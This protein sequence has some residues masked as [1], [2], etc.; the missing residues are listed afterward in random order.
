[1]N[2]GNTA[3]NITSWHIVF[4][5]YCNLKC[6]YCST[7]YGQF[8]NE[9]PSYMKKVTSLK[10]AEWIFRAPQKNKS[11]SLCFEGGETLLKFKEFIEYVQYLNSLAKTHN[12]TLSIDVG[13]NGVLLDKDIMET[14]AANNI[15]LSFSIDGSEETHDLCRKDHQ[16]DKT[17]QK[18]L[19]NWKL[20]KEISRNSPNPVIC[21]IQSVYSGHSDL[22]EVL[23]FWHTQGERIVNV[24]IQHPSRFV[25]GQNLEDLEKR[26]QRYLESFKKIAYQKAALL[27]IPTFLTDF[28]GPN[29]L[30]KIWKDIF[31]GTSV[32]PCGAAVNTLGVT[33]EGDL[34]PCETFI[35]SPTDQGRGSFWKMGDV[36]NGLD[37]EKIKT[38]LNARN[39]VLTE[40]D[41]CDTGH[42][43]RGGCFAAGEKDDE[44]SLNRVGGCG[45]M[46][47][48][49]HIARESY[50]GMK[51]QF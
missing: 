17:Q 48:I 5:Q 2:I 33:A 38:F 49:I 12:V 32:T 51:E 39:R 28:K 27:T 21:R 20:F 34:Y 43:C 10:L 25:A 9:K 42:L 24:N 26:R 19:E 1:M 37:Y 31:L 14:C 40:C 35:G 18:A 23:E 50:A 11:V 3:D 29:A 45:F 44:I 41:D 30:Y 46:K 7:G 16:G 6:S 36:F 4:T 13:T 8:G 22:E 15:G 47:E